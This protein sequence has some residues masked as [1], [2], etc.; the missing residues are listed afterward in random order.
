MTSYTFALIHHYQ[1]LADE[2]EAEGLKM[3]KTMTKVMMGNDTPIYVKTTRIENVT[4]YIY[5]LQRYSTRDKNHGK[6]IER[7]IRACW[8]AFVKYRDVVKGNNR[9]GMKRQNAYG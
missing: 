6:E 7:S 1:E 4:R 8:M 2:S 3:N 5:L 9:S